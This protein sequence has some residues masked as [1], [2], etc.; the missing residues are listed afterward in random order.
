MIVQNLGKEVYVVSHHDPLSGLHVVGFGQNA[1]I[2]EGCI[3]EDIPMANAGGYV[4]VVLNG[5]ETPSMVNADM[6][7]GLSPTDIK[8]PA[9]S[10]FF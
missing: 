1:R 7:R 10:Y 8:T 6:V 9:F 4:A 3:P 2:Y 5:G